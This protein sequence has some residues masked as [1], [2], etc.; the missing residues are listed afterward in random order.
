MEDQGA[1][2][3]KQIEKEGPDERAQV[4]HGIEHQVGIPYTSTS[5]LPMGSI[6]QQM[7][8]PPMNSLSESVFL[9]RQYL[10]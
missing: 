10:L 6:S 2:E 5:D 3:V 8:E 9:L 1:N 7:I 4:L